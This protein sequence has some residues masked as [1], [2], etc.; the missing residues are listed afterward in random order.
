MVARLKMARGR[1]GGRRAAMRIR[2]CFYAAG[3]GEWLETR[4]LPAVI[5]GD[6][7]VLHDNKW[8]C[9]VRLYIELPTAAR[10]AG[11]V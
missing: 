7:L 8:R 6:Y 9:T 2:R 11:S 3:R 5:P 4:A 1:D 10:S